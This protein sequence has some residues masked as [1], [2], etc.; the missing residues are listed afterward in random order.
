MSPRRWRLY[1]GGPFSKRYTAEPQLCGVS[2][3][4]FLEL[5]N[6]LPQAA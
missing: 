3:T 1:G 2:S 6:S 5:I 4:I